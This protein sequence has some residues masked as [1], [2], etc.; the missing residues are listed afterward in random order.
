MTWGIILLRNW[1]TLLLFKSVKLISSLKDRFLVTIKPKSS[2]LSTYGRQWEP[3]ISCIFSSNPPKFRALHF[4][5]WKSRQLRE[6]H[7]CRESILFWTRDSSAEV[8]ILRSSA[9][10]EKWLFEISWAMS[11]MNKT[12]RSGPSTLRWGT[13]EVTGSGKETDL[14]ILTIWYRLSKYELNKWRKSRSNS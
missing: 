5:E 11:L 14:L 9:N 10:K 4:K 12:N 8:K 1:K 3:N 13:P 6:K 2:I 7:R